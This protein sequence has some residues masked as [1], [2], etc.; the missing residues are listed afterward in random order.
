MIGDRRA[1]ML[2]HA[3]ELPGRGLVRM[4][5]G[6]ARS[7]TMHPARQMGT[8]QKLFAALL[9]VALIGSLPVTAL[10]GITGA[11]YCGTVASSGS[12]DGCR[13]SGPSMNNS[14]C[15]MICAMSTA[16]AAGA[17]T[18]QLPTVL[19][20]R[21]IACAERAIQLISGPPDTAPPKA[22]SAKPTV[23]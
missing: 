14:S 23:V 7:V 19:G 10:A 3:A 15:S 22:I 4:G 18:E 11:P 9:M 20:E 1:S 6:P 13:G 12:D 5:I 16:A 8:L 21:P 17:V 2:A